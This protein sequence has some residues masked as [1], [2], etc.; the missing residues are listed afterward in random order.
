MADWSTLGDIGTAFTG[1]YDAASKKRTL[2]EIGQA[3]QSGDY[4]AGAKAAF[5]LGDVTTGLALSKLAQDRK[6]QATFASQFP[7]SRA[8]VRPRRA[9][10]RLPPTPRRSRAARSTRGSSSM[11][12]S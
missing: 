2:A 8:A 7:A 4:D 5:G 9:V 3:L 6:G 1:A 10:A 12:G 11:T